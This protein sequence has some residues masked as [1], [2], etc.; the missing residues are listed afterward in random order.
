MRAYADF[1]FYKNEYGGT[2]VGEEAFR[3][4]SLQ[5]TALINKITFQRAT[6]TEEVKAAMCAAV[7]TL[8]CSGA[9]SGIAAENNDGYSVTY[10]DRTPEEAE[11]EAYR[12]IRSFLPKELTNRGCRE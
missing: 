2:T 8:Y 11:R 4:L 3:A 6:D 9:H 7:D 5:C 10:R 1:S 12:V